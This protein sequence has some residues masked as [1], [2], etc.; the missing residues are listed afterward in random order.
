MK[1]NIVFYFYFYFR[2]F[3]SR[4]RIFGRSGSGLSKKVWSGPGSMKKNPDP[5]HRILRYVHIT[6][7][8]LWMFTSA[9][10][11]R[12]W[13][14]Y[15]DQASSLLLGLFTG[16]K[17]EFMGEGIRIKIDWIHNTDRLYEI[18]RSFEAQGA[19][20]QIS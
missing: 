15:S 17:T 9:N 12:I 6:D 4:I 8:T 13:Q 2:P 14:N 10:K 20:L 5:K 7:P 3:S 1:Y 11:I 19:V 16:S 18:F